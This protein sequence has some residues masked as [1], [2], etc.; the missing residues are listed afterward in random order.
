MDVRR[1]R[2]PKN[3][4]NIGRSAQ[5]SAKQGDGPSARGTQSAKEGNSHRD[6]VKLAHK[7]GY[8]F[9]YHKQ[10]AL[11]LAASLIQSCFFKAQLS[12]STIKLNPQTQLPFGAP[13][14]APCKERFLFTI[15]S[16]RRIRLHP[17]NGSHYAAR[18]TM[19][20]GIHALHPPGQP[21]AVEMAPAIYS[22]R[23]DLL[24]YPFFCI[25]PGQGFAL[26]AAE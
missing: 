20:T 17:A 14:P 4:V 13:P 6:K 25:A 11:L 12:N 23:S 22:P 3:P 21:A 8:V 1:S 7:C 2:L 16:S 26:K 19:T 24:Q 9:I 10:I 5:K 18:K 15:L